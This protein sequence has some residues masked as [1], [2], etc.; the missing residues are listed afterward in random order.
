MTHRVL[1]TPTGPDVSKFTIDRANDTTVEHAKKKIKCVLSFQISPS[2]KGNYRKK[3][4]RGRR[5]AQYK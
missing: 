3:R 2:C 1:V 5:T 4:T